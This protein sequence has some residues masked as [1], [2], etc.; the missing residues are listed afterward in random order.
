MATLTSS[1]VVNIFAR[2]ALVIGFSF[3]VVR[4]RLAGGRFS[5]EQMHDN[6]KC[7]AIASYYTA[8]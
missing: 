7:R 5:R 8:R 4:F 2:D 1:A 6:G 3:R